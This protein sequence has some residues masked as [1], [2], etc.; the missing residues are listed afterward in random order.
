VIRRVAATL[1]RTL[2]AVH[3][4]VA[5]SLVAPR[6]VVPLVAAV[7]AG[8]GVYWLGRFHGDLP[9]QGQALRAYLLPVALPLLY[10]LFEADPPTWEAGG[11]IAMAYAVGVATGTPAFVYLSIVAFSCLAAGDPR[12]R[13]TQGR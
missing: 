10:Q 1:V 11:A 3:T 9:W 4:A 7:I 8:A 12:R 2:G 13:G 5:V 6:E